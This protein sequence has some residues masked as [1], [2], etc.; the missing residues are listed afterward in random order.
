MK[1][2]MS[3]AVVGIVLAASSSAMAA[4]PRAFTFTPAFFLGQAPP[5]PAPEGVAPV[6]APDPVSG[7]AQALFNCVKYVDKDE[8]AP[9]AVPK[10]IKVLDPCPQPKCCDPCACCKP[11]PPKCVN[12]TIC[13]PKCACACPK[14]TCSRNGKR[15]RY[16]YGKYAVD[17]RVK[18]GYIEVDY[19]D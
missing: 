8:M 3:L 13:V 1:K 12:I 11:A 9:C 4:G 14:V 18:K 2:L 5:A 17:V 6:A 19:Q 16:D 15:V 10:I 7:G